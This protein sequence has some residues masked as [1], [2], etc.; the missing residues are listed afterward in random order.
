VDPLHTEKPS[1]LVYECIVP[2]LMQYSLSIHL[3]AAQILYHLAGAGTHASAENAAASIRIGQ[4]CAHAIF[5]VDYL[6]RS[7]RAR[8]ESECAERNW[9]LFTEATS[10][11]ALKLTHLSHQR[12]EDEILIPR[13]SVLYKYVS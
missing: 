8:R 10:K 9:C 12:W 2:A 3:D 4:V 5:A 13:A 6:A 7:V 11:A 1:G